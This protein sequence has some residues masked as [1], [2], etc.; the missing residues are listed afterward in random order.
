[1]KGT[2][3]VQIFLGLANKAG[4]RVDWIRTSDPFFLNLVGDQAVLGPPSF[5]KFF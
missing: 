3:P 2:L 4:F 1:M 5:L